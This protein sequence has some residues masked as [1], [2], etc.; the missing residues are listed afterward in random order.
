MGDQPKEIKLLGQRIALKTSGT[1][2]ETD[3]AVVELVTQLLGRVEARLVKRQDRRSV[4][5]HYVTLVALLDLAEAYVKAKRQVA[6]YQSELDH[7]LTKIISDLS[8]EVALESG[9]SG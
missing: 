7:K 4:A 8:G 3:Q 2:P 9:E 6:T 5:P 1:D